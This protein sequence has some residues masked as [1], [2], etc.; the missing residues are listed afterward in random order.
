MEPVQVAIFVRLAL[1]RVALACWLW[2]GGGWITSPL[3]AQDGGP[4]LLSRTGGGGAGWS[5][6]AE[7]TAA[8]DKGN[9]KARAQLGEMLLRGEDIAKDV[10][11]ALVL[12][13]QAARAGD[14]SA[15][16]RIGMLLEEGTTVPQDQ[17]RAVGICARRRSG[18]SPMRSVMS[19]WLTRPGAV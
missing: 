4:V 16:F 13:E 1:P 3:R 2:C 5:N 12:L 15:A 11:R 7:L 6:V 9:P 10:S 8:A 17:A 14:A 19:V 18:E